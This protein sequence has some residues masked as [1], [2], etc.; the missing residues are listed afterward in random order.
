MELQR[1]RPWIAPVLAIVGGTGLLVATFLTWY[2]GVNVEGAYFNRAVGAP[3]YAGVFSTWGEGDSA[4]Q[5]F[6]GLDIALAACAAAAV[7]SGASILLHRY[8]VARVACLVAGVGG[9]AVGAW[10][11][12]RVFDRPGLTGLGPGAVIGFAALVL[13]LVG[14]WLS[15]PPRRRRPMTQASEGL[16]P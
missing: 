2:S 9:L 3:A 10:T 4:W 7:I 16:Q 5:A 15:L 11:L 13:V 8:G 14:V 1:F 6:A 12:E